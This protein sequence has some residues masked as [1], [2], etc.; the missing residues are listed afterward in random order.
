MA[1]KLPQVPELMLECSG[2][3]ERLFFWPPKEDL[4]GTQWEACYRQRTG[5]NAPLFP[6]EGPVIRKDSRESAASWVAVGSQ[7]GPPPPT[8]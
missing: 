3:Y 7:A 1:E 4:F 5:V 2:L 8:F 6:L